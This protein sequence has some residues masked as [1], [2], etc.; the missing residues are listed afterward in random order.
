[1]TGKIWLEENEGGIS[2]GIWDGG[3]EPSDFF[4]FFD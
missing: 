4:D 1:M 3:G 2:G